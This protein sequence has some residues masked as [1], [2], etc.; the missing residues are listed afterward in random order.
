MKHCSDA[1]CLEC[2]FESMAA[3]PGVWCDVDAFLI[4]PPRL[5][6]ARAARAVVETENAQA[7]R[8]IAPLLKSPLRFLD[9]GVAE[10]PAFQTPGA[11]RMLCA[12]AHALLDRRPKFSAALA[13]AAAEIATKLE[14]PVASRQ[15]LRAMALRERANALRYLG[16]FREALDAL[17]EAEQLFRSGDPSLA[18]FELAIVFYVRGTVLIQFDETTAEALAISIRAAEAFHEYG[19]RP[20]EMSARLLNGLALLHLRRPAEALDALEQLIGD[21]RRAD[22]KRMMAYGFQSA[23]LASTDLH[24]LDNAERH[25]A[26]ALAI[27]DELGNAIEQTRVGWALAAIPVARGRLEEGATALEAARRDLLGLGLKNDHGLATLE[28]AEVCLALGRSEGVQDACRQI[29]LEFESE[30]MMQKARLALAYVH[31]A[32]ARRRATPELLRSVRKYLVQ[33]PR[34]PNVAFAPAS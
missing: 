18:P 33:L 16:S 2:E 21:A 14:T 29:V 20:R 8:R 26:D 9:A 22:D 6:E 25:F 7:T 15:F 30:G 10:E 12:E 13:A 17:A 23:A 28:W 32:L 11:V 3:D 31:E 4:P 1:E 24:D 19:D 5:G 27:Y 34:Q